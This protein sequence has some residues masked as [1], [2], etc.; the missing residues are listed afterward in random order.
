MQPPV[1]VVPGITASTLR[2]EYPLDAKTVWALIS[3]DYDRIALHPDDLRYERDEPAR[4]TADRLFEVPYD[5]LVGELRH[6]LADRHDQ[7]VPVFTFPYD[8]RIPLV[9]VQ[10]QLGAFMDEV[11]ARTRLLRHY[12]AAGYA[13]DPRID[14]VGHSMGGLVIAGYLAASK[15]RRVR[16]VA[17]IAAPF[18]GSFEAVLKVAVGTADLGLG[19]S[20]SRERE[21]ARLTPA[22][23]HLVP[24]YG[25]D[26]LSD[27]PAWLDLFDA[28]AWQPGVVATIAEYLRLF[29]LN[30]AR[31]K[32]A[33]EDR[34][35]E[36]LQAMLDDAKA[37][38]AAVEG[39]TLESVGMT[40]DD[41]LCLVGV[42]EETR[43]QLRIVDDGHGQPFFDLASAQRMNGYPVPKRA[44]DGR[45][46]QQ[47]WDTG[48]GTVPYPGAGASF[49]PVEK[50]VALCDG[51]FGYW[52]LRDRALE[53]VAGLHGLLPAMNVAQKLIVA[54]LRAP[55]GQPGRANPG[56][57]GR[58]A[59]GLVIDAA[60][61]PPIR[62]LR[63]RV[64]PEMEGL[65]RTKE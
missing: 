42:G 25:G 44:P 11:V 30:P 20:S 49:I 21:V 43:L 37:H 60:W 24:S 23:Y 65:P 40:A 48:D 5:G 64:L 7:P 59:P 13:G 10:A 50:I 35:R 58:R 8:W 53:A 18:R 45:I 27:N 31:A 4:V 19:K 46:T 55:A 12:D 26:V 52:E 9:H 63:E 6:D 57:W 56:I 1:I 22:L 29:G 41:W 39:F 33:R 54:H 32:G 2:D 38:R 51:D 34:A 61:Q 36:I 15:D 62:G 28:A 47:L 14:L 17:T 3:K 16:K